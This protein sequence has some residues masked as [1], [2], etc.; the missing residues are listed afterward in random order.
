MKLV[1]DNKIVYTQVQENKVDLHSDAGMENLK[2][3][4]PTSYKFVAD[5]NVGNF[6]LSRNYLPKQMREMLSKKVI[7]FQKGYAPGGRYYS[8][9]SENPVDNKST[10]EHF[11]HWCFYDKGGY[12]PIVEGTSENKHY[13]EQLTQ[14]LLNRYVD[15]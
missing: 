8:N 12:P 13:F 14:D 5:T 1:S 11:K 7:S 4:T 15:R 10:I 3:T 9:P 6:I 2:P